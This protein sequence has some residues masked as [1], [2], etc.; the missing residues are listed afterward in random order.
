MITSMLVLGENVVDDASRLGCFNGVDLDV[1]GVGDQRLSER[2]AASRA[3]QSDRLDC[4]PGL[5]R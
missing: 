5:T 3:R 1:A 2:P 4:R